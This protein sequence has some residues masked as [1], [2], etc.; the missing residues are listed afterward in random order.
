[1]RTALALL[2]MLLPI[3]AAQAQPFEV[4]MRSNIEYVEH[5][6]TKLAGEACPPM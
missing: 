5:D 1:M 2:A 4:T 3:S 6:G